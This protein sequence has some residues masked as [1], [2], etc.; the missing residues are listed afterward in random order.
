MLIGADYLARVDLR[1][2]CMVFLLDRLDLV[3][4]IDPRLKA[5]A[6]FGDADDAI[7]PKL[8]DEINRRGERFV[9]A[10]GSVCSVM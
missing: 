7:P 1:E 9:G 10:S 3:Q 5:S 2:A 6:T 8:L 4:N